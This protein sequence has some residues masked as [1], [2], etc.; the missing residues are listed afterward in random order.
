MH[1]HLQNTEKRGEVT[2]LEKELSFYESVSV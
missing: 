2:A 1:I